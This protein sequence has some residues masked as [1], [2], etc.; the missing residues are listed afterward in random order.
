MISILCSSCSAASL[1][2][3][4]WHAENEW[5]RQRENSCTASENRNRKLDEMWPPRPRIDEKQT[6]AKTLMRCFRFFTRL[7]S[8]Y[9]RYSLEHILRSIVCIC[10][11]PPSTVLLALLSSKHA[12]A[13]AM[14]PPT[15]YAAS[16]AWAVCWCSITAIVDLHS[17]PQHVSLILRAGGNCPRTLV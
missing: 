3:R 16:V 4:S 9:C 13:H 17:R 7:P 10:R 12:P 15:M 8:T 14:N 11:L 6:H 1:R 2:R 5:W